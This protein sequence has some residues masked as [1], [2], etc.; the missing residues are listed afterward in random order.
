M[1]AAIH[2]SLTASDPAP[3]MSDVTANWMHESRTQSHRAA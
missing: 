2:G 1:S 3:V